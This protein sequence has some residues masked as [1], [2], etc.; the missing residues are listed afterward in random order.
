MIAKHNQ[1]NWKYHVFMHRYMLY[2]ENHLC[3]TESSFVQEAVHVDDC[4]A[5]GKLFDMRWPRGILQEGKKA[6]DVDRHV[7]LF[8]FKKVEAISS[9][10]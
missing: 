7:N 5:A 2:L 1:D 6:W 10:M 3:T 4:G 9:M 8:F